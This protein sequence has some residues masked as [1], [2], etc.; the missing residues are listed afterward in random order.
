MDA[1]DGKLEKWFLRHARRLMPLPTAPFR[2]Q[3]VMEAISRQAAELGLEIHIR[4]RW[5][6]YCSFTKGTGIRDPSPR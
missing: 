4:T 1:T 3:F 5:A 6:I 2:E